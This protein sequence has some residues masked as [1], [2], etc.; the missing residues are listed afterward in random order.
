MAGRFTGS[1]FV[2]ENYLTRGYYWPAGQI[3][4]FDFAE[5]RGPREQILLRI[6]H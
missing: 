5:N 4:K 6:S 3:H 1:R 2:I